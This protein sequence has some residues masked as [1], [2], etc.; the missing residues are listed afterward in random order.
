MRDKPCSNWELGETEQSVLR[1]A[2]VTGSFPA[3]IHVYMYKFCCTVRNSALVTQPK[4]GLQSSHNKKSAGRQLRAATAAPQHQQHTKLSQLSTSPSWT[5]NFSPHICHLTA[6]SFTSISTRE[7]M[8]KRNVF[9]MYKYP[10]C[11]TS[12]KDPAFFLI[13]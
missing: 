4:G 13:T 5:S 12:P 11:K 9:S 8:M 7:E 3:S 2:P 10:E 6:S 1:A